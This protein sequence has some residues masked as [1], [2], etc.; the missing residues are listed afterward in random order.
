MIFFDEMIQCEIGEQTG[1]GNAKEKQD[2]FNGEI[3][4]KNAGDI[5]GI[6]P[7]NPRRRKNNI[8]GNKENRSD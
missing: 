5:V 6:E 3:K 4:N 8:P 2:F 1:I 7:P